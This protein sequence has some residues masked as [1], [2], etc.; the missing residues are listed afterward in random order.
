MINEGKPPQPSFGTIKVTKHQ[1]PRL[2]TGK[3]HFPGWI[4]LEEEEVSSDQRS[5]LNY[6]LL[7]SLQYSISTVS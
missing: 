3:S 5:F 2:K 6:L 4:E 7:L 1:S